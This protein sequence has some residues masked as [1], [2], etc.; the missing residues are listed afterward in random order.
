MLTEFDPVNTKLVDHL[1]KRPNLPETHNC[2]IIPVML[3]TTPNNQNEA[4][5]SAAKSTGA[6]KTISQ[7]S[8]AKDVLLSLIEMLYNSRKVE[9]LFKDLKQSK[10]VAAK[11][12]YLPIFNN[13]IPMSMKKKVTLDTESVF[14]SSTASSAEFGV[15][16]IEDSAEYSSMLPEIFHHLTKNTTKNNNTE[17]QLKIEEL[18]PSNKANSLHVSTKSPK[19]KKKQTVESE[20][21]PQHSMIDSN[22]AHCNSQTFAQSIQSD[23][24]FDDHSSGNMSSRPSRPVSEQ[25]L[26][27]SCRPVW[28]GVTKGIV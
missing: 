27:S 18:A 25:L 28:N 23:L 11:Y 3:L 20:L 14:S 12:P 10:V 1:L 9:D 24:H 26:D 19:D 13:K 21:D 15:E 5:E 4:N 2:P 8:H 6:L 7:S 16:E 22:A 17:M